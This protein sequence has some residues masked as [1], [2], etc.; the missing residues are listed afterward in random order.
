MSS[1][2]VACRWSAL[3]LTS[4]IASPA[5]AQGSGS[6]AATWQARFDVAAGLGWFSGRPD[7]GYEQWYTDSFWL[8]AEGGYFLTEHVKLEV[9]ASA[10]SEGL[11]WS[12]ETPLGPTGQPQSYISSQHA[13]RVSTFSAGV[14]YQFGRNAWVHPYLGAGVDIDRDRIRTS[15]WVQPAY[16]PRQ[17]SRQPHQIPDVQTTETAARL[18]GVGGVKVFFSQRVFL[19]ADAKAAGRT[20]LDKVVFR[21][22]VGADF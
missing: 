12:N 11:S 15:S 10:A 13:H 4:L 9:G 17:P 14:T 19:R 22:M 16:N 21:A 7:V 1:G 8:G 20:S 2:R 3:L 18:F 6:A 5:L